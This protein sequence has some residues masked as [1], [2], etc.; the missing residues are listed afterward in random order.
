VTLCSRN[1]KSFGKRFP[2]IVEGLVDV[3]D[4]TVIDG[5]INAVTLVPEVLARKLDARCECPPDFRPPRNH[6]HRSAGRFLMH[7]S[8][9]LQVKITPTYDSHPRV[10]N[11]VRHV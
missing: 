8:W 10:T 7:L 4:E 2:L 5:E 11:L 9:R 3:P 1:Q 6:F